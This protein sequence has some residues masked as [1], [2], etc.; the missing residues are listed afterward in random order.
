MLEIEVGTTGRVRNG[1]LVRGS[2]TKRWMF[3][4]KCTGFTGR[5]GKDIQF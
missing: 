3:E 2:A 1:R 4:D 5:E